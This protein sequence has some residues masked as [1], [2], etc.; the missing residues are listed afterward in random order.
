MNRG[1]PHTAHT[2]AFRELEVQGM[3]ELLGPCSRDDV[4]LLLRAV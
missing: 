4:L 2:A 3:S 1:F